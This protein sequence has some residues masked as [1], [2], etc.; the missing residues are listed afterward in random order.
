MEQYPKSISKGPRLRSGQNSGFLRQLHKGC[1][2]VAQGVHKDRTLHVFSQ[3]FL[4]FKL[5]RRN[6]GA[7]GHFK[8][9]VAHGHFKFSVAHGHFQISVAHG[10]FKFS[11]ARGHIK[12]SVA[13]D[14]REKKDV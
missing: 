14:I 3:L 10:Q 1:T 4:L 7:Q 6:L 2:G 12:F 9:S 5:E 13:M 8:F 11:V